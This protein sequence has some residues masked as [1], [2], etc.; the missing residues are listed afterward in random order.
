MHR[1]CR[2]RGDGNVP[3]RSTSCGVALDDICTRTEREIPSKVTAMRQLVVALLAAGPLLGCTHDPPP[4]CIDV[5]TSCAP[6]Y[7]PTFTN[8]YNMTLRDTCGSTR[9]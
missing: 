3:Y 9:E 5:D 6:L 7:M 1:L 4:K 2:C 8:I